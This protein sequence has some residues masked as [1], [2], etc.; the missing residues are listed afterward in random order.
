M[1]MNGRVAYVVKRY[2]RFS[3]TFIVNEI[4]AHEAAGLHIEIYSLYPGGDTHFQNAISSVRAP[5][6]Y[7]PSKGLDAADL[8]TAIR[9]TSLIISDLRNKLAY[10]FETDPR[11][12]YQALLLAQYVRRNELDHIHSHFATSSTTVARLASLFTDVPYSFTAHAK[13][14]YHQDTKREELDLKIRDASAVVTVSHFN[15]QYLRETFGD[16]ADKVSCVYN[17]MDVNSL[18][19]KSPKDRRTEIISVGRFVEK[20]GFSY[21]I[22]ACSILRNQGR[23]FHCTIIGFGELEMQMRMQVQLLG[24]NDFVELIGP[25][26]QSEVLR[27]IQNASVLVAPCVVGEDGNRDGLPTVL[28]ESMALGTPCISTDVTGIPEVID[29]GVTGLL[30]PQ[31]NSAVLA[32]MIDEVFSDEALRVML[33]ENARRLIE[34]EFDI[35][36]NSALLRSIFAGSKQFTGMQAVIR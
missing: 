22:E 2:P 34:R 11:Y 27:R 6:Y 21:L 13:D 1:N 4:L 16:I 28:I 7:L 32:Q 10:G 31:K 30:A 19:Y 23:N 20:K 3:E 35:R 26:P 15:V 5:V 24:L 12:V 29:H 18:E 14:I 33:S 17:G 9:D 36:R 8:W 25:L